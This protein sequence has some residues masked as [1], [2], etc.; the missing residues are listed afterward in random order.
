MAKITKDRAN[1][2]SSFLSFNMSLFII[3]TNFYPSLLGN[4]EQYSIQN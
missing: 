2:N 1:T 3:I 4:L